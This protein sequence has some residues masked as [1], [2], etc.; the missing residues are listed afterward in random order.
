MARC[1]VSKQPLYGY[2]HVDDPH[3]FIPDAECCSPTELEAH[4]QACSEYGTAHYKPNKGC[5]SEYDDS[6][7]LVS[8]VA[9]TS[10]GI[11]TNLIDACDG[12]QTPAFEPLMTCHECGGAEFCPACWPA[13]EREH[14]RE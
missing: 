2:P 14:D 4:R 8:H 5:Y 7:R 6:G 12:C 10:W 3:D 1:S 9:R 11:G 13:H